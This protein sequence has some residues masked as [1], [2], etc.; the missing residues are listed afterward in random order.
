MCKEF[1]STLTGPALQWYINLPSRSIASFPILSDKFVEQFASGRDLEKTSDG[2]YKILQHRAEPL[3]HSPL[4]PREGPQGGQIGPNRARRETLSKT[5]QGLWEQKQGKIPEPADREG[6][7]DGSIHMA[8]HLSPLRLKAGADQCSGQM[9]Q[10]VKWSQKMNAPDSLRNPGLWC[11]FHRDQG[12][13]KE[14]CVA[15]KIEVN[16]LLKKGHL[17]ESLSEK[18][19]SHLSKETTGR[20]TEAAPLSPPP[21][22]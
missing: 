14:D 4:Q 12:H 19:K 21:Q 11:D 13:K 9:G 2:L 5:S 15:L 7:M 3:A 1:V 18:D 22:D 16:E 10:L 17:R 20:P 8:R 6:R